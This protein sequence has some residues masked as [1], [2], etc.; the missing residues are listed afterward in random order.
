MIKNFIFGD[1]LLISNFPVESLKANK[2]QQKR[3]LILQYS[4]T[5]KLCSFFEPQLSQYSGKYSATTQPK[6]F[7]WLVSGK[8]FALHHF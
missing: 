4:F 7:S 2:N 5:Q 1:Y 3:S 6:T 8:T